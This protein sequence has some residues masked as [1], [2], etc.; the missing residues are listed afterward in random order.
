MSSDPSFFDVIE[1]AALRLMREAVASRI[2]IYRDVKIDGMVAQI[3]VKITAEWEP[4]KMPFPME[5][6]R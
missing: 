5:I 3:R 1:R 6:E 2:D 4:E